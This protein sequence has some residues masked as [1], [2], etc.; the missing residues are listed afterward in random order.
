MRKFQARWWVTDPLARYHAALDAVALDAGIALRLI[1]T[2]D[3]ED[4]R[5]YFL[6]RQRQIIEAWLQ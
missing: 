3:P 1:R 6:R 5:R 4:V 2:A